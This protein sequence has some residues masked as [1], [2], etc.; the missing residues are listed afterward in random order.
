[1]QEIQ[2]FLV[3]A[4]TLLA[5]LAFQTV[6]VL[7]LGLA[8]LLAV[9]GVRFTDALAWQTLFAR[10][11][12]VALALGLLWL[13]VLATAWPPLLERTGNVLGPVV[14]ALV[15]ALLLTEA[16]AY[17]FM[18]S[19]N[20]TLQSLALWLTAIGYSVALSLVVV[21][22]SWM[23]E[24]V[25]ATLIDGR[26]QVVQWAA[27]F[28]SA[29]VIEAWLSTVFGAL[30]LLG[31]L[32]QSK[33]VGGRLDASLDLPSGW[34]SGLAVLGALGLLGLLW[35]LARTSGADAASSDSPTFYM[36]LM[37]GS[38]SSIEGL[39]LRVLF[40]MWVLT[41]VGL[42]LGM[43]STAVRSRLGQFMVQLPLFTAP[44]VWCLVWWQLYVW[45]QQTLV[46]GLP[47]ADLVSLQPA[48]VLASGLVLVV[49]AIVACAAVLA[50]ALGVPAQPK[51]GQ[52]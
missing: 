46:S 28:Q 24:P 52:A 25:G 12:R 20:Q 11:A 43:A 26:F 3:Q 22:E 21:A 18:S 35:L 5:Q 34:R 23:R 16:V 29:G 38:A 44:L 7:G 42:V 2:L 10:V 40:V 4:Q 33:L 41:L 50:R 30:V 47:V 9:L 27:L 49:G 6:A 1:M 36:R 19:V 17:R 45:P 15:A 31:A 51:G 8:W 48:W 39:A 14:I 32:V 13:T 37:Q